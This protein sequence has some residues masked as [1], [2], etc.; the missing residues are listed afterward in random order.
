[1]ARTKQTARKTASAVALRIRIPVRRARSGI[2]ACQEERRTNRMTESAP[3]NQWIFSS[4]VLPV[5]KWTVVLRTPSRNHTSHSRASY[6][7]NRFPSSTNPLL[8]RASANDP[9]SLKG[10]LPRVL[11]V[12]LEEYHTDDTLSYQEITFDFGTQDKFDRWEAQVPALVAQIHASKFERKIIFITVHS[13][14]MRGDLF[15]GKDEMGEDVALVP[16]NFLTCLFSGGLK[17]VINLSTVFLLSCGPLVKYQES[18]NSLKDA[19]VNLKPEYTIAFSADRF[20]SSSLKTFIAAFG[21]CVVVERHELS[22]VFVDLLN[23]SLELRMHSDTYLFHT[24]ART[25]ASPF[26]V[27]GTR[28]SWYH[29]HRRPW[30]VALPMGCPNC[31]AI[32]SWSESR[33]VADCD[34]TDGTRRNAVQNDTTARKDVARRKAASRVSACES[35]MCG[36]KVYAHPPSGIYELIKTNHGVPSGWIKQIF[37]SE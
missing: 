9:Q 2:S 14:V 32:R 36:Y 33:T 26:S 28:Y 34:V 11:K 35:E 7:E 13:E 24:K 25:S 15:A 8:F 10:S 27:V 20:I 29:N 21:V 12:A 4:F 22:E 3:L 1:M 5:M 18:L 23:L 6:K 17:H 16:N 37:L 30:G 19:I 31:G